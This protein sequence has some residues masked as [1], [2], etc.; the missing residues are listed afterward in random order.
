MQKQIILI[1]YRATGKTSVGKCLAAALGIPFFD[2][3]RELEKRCG[4]SIAELVAS[5]GWPYFRALEKELLVE[6][7]GKNDQVVS[8]GGGAIL[9]Q[10]IWQQLKE[11]SF[12]VWLTA[13]HETIYRRLMGDSQTSSQRP[14]LTEGNAYSEIVS[15]LQEREPL[16]RTGAH[17]TVDTGVRGIDE[18]VEAVLAEVRPSA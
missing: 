2:M 13:D 16:Y 17:F 7:I 9:H 3:D 1:G 15:V 10:D 18:V 8:T 4:Q 12:V 14:A 6:I 11:S 5:Q